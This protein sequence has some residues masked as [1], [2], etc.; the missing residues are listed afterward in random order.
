MAAPLGEIVKNVKLSHVVTRKSNDNSIHHLD[1]QLPRMTAEGLSKYPAKS[2]MKTS[3]DVISSPLSPN[4]HRLN[5]RD[6]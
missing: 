2:H 5:Y 6:T 3:F 4:A 1:Q